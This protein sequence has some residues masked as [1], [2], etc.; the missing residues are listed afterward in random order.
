LL[1]ES[2]VEE[3]RALHEKIEITNENF[4][5]RNIELQDIHAQLEMLAA[6]DV[7]T[8]LYNRRYILER[9]EEKLP[10]IKRHHLDC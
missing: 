7:L 6:R 2:Y 10:E 5:K 9:I 8:G 3:L 4:V 1:N